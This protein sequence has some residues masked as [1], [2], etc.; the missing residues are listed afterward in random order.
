MVQTGIY[1]YLPGLHQ[2]IKY[3]VDN[4]ILLSGEYFFA[5]CFIKL[6]V[7]KF[8]KLSNKEN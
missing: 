3:I 4:H 1:L 5:M 7:D 8:W 6:K 2:G